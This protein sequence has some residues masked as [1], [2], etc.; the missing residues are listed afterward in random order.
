MLTLG[1]VVRILGDAGSDGWT[2]EARR[3]RA[4]R[5][6]TYGLVSEHHDSHGLCY[7]VI[8]ADGSTASFEPEELFPIAVPPSDK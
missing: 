2:E 1:T 5:Q 6:H 8:F 3:A 7:D 4:R